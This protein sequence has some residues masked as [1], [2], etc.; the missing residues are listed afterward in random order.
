MF[1]VKEMPRHA[2]ED[3]LG[4]SNV[5]LEERKAAVRDIMA[6]H[7]HISP[8]WVEYLWNYLRHFTEEECRDMVN[9]GELKKRGEPAKE[10]L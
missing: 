8:Q 3:P 1:D 2:Q 7:P 5:Q 6:V 10:N 4:L 9:A